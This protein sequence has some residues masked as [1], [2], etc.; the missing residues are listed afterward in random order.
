MKKIILDVLVIIILASQLIGCSVKDSKIEDTQFKPE[1]TDETDYG[2]VNESGENAMNEGQSEIDE[3]GE[4]VEAGSGQNTASDESSASSKD[5]MSKDIPEE[6]I[7]A[8]PNKKLSSG[9]TL[10]EVKVLIDDLR[11]LMRSNG[12][13]EEVIEAEVRKIAEEFGTTLEEV[14]R[15]IVVEQPAE[16][17]AGNTGSET[18]KGSSGNKGGSQTGGGKQTGGSKSGSGSKSSGGGKVAQGGSKGSG[19]T[20]G[21]IIYER[22]PEDGDITRR[23]ADVL[24]GGKAEDGTIDPNTKLHM[25]GEEPSKQ[26]NQKQ[27]NEEAAK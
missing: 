15:V 25:P 12:R 4:N 17:N 20:D 18:G 14:D 27:E 26:D 11:N 22:S 16:S 8:D 1:V 21:S 5:V 19:S 7:P 13:S 23:R 24:F 2:E 10:G 3:V 9:L 6:I